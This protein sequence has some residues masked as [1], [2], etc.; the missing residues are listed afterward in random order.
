M[1]D[2]ATLML[3]WEA[4]HWAI[5][6]QF[7]WDRTQSNQG[8]LELQ[9]NSACVV[10]GRGKSKMQVYISIYVKNCTD[11]ADVKERLWNPLYDDS[12]DGVR[13]A[14]RKTWCAILWQ[15]MRFVC[16][17]V[18]FLFQMCCLNCSVHNFLMHRKRLES[19]DHNVE[20]ILTHLQQSNPTGQWPLVYSCGK[21][22][23][24]N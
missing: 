4:L 6:S 21:I 2:T 23:Q 17:A 7:S 5:Y 10:F 11:L 12:G 20:Q 24:S 16:V 3:F 9:S 22:L 18:V 19:G 8:L 14:S 13:D 1:R 15:E